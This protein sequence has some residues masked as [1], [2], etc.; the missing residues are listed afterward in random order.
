MDKP[1]KKNYKNED[2]FLLELYNLISERKKN[3]PKNSY[4]ASLFNQGLPKILEKVEEESDEV[5]KAAKKETKTR[6]IEE[7]SDLLYHLLVLLVEKK[8]S[9]KDIAEELQ[10]RERR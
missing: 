1:N 2:Q 10:R 3:L 7:S 6:L 9:L 5:L 4:T 8:I